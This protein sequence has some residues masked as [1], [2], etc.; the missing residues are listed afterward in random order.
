ME[1][2]ELR[3]HLGLT[4]SE[5]AKRLGITR[6]YYG[7]IEKG[8]EASATLI[9]MRQ[10][11]ERSLT[12]ESRLSE[13]SDLPGRSMVTESVSSDTIE[14]EE[15]L[16][17]YGQKPVEDS[18]PNS[19]VIFDPK[20]REGDSRA[21]ATVTAVLDH[22]KPWLDATKQDPNIAPVMLHVL[23]KHLPHSDLEVDPE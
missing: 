4:Q 6:S 15:F 17:Q 7:A 14:V 1:F 22:L 10:M 13:L 2:K 18:S 23:R 11:M 21:P 8:R 19:T 3:T 5:M 20:W 12:L 16:A 9:N